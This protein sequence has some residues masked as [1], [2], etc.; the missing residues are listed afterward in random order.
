MKK[1]PT[2]VLVTSFDKALNGIP[3]S[4]GGRQVV[5]SRPRGSARAKA[6]KQSMCSYF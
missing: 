5:G 4:L 2:S 3:L 1:N 6:C